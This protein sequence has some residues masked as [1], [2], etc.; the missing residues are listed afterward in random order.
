MNYITAALTL[1]SGHSGLEIKIQ[2]CCALYGTVK[3]TKAQPAVEDVHICR[4]MSDAWTNMLLD[5]RRHVTIF[6]RS[7]LWT[8]EDLCTG[9]YEQSSGLGRD[10]RGDTPLEGMFGTEVSY[11]TGV[12]GS[13]LSAIPSDLFMM[14][15]TSPNLILESDFEAVCH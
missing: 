5:V 3:C 1:V 13:A 4:C 12:P 10:K 7:Q 11:K 2:C 15:F 9:N 6:E 14:L 8:L